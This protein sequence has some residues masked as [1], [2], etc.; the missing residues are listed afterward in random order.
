M[1]SRLE[2]DDRAAGQV[3]GVQPHLVIGVE[4]LRRDRADVQAGGTGAADVTYG[5][6]QS[7][8]DLGLC[9]PALRQIAETGADE[10]SRQ[11]GLLGDVQPTAVEPGPAA[12]VRLP[13]L[14]RHR[15]DHRADQTGPGRRV[16][17]ALDDGDRHRPGRDAVGVVDRAVDRVDHPGETRGRPG[18]VGLLTE[19]PVLGPGPGEGV[20]D[21]GLHGPVG[22]GDDVGDRG[23]AVGDGHT[24]LAHLLGHHRALLGDSEGETVQLGHGSGGH[25][26]HSRGL[27]GHGRPR[28]VDVPARGPDRSG[29]GTAA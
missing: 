28:R 11:L 6:Q 7:G 15:A 24:R 8:D 17:I 1:G 12:P 5:R 14:P 9:H 25:V 3:P 4:P 19:E 13:G 2:G 22:L 27:R 20:A 16:G 18:L 21:R 29:P 23:L 10:C 26:S